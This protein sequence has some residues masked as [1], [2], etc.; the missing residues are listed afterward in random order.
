MIYVEKNIKTSFIL[1]YKYYILMVL[2][3]ITD[4]MDKGHIPI[5]NLTLTIPGYSYNNAIN[6]FK[7]LDKTSNNKIKNSYNKILL[8]NIPLLNI[9]ISECN[10]CG[11]K[12]NTLLQSKL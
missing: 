4:C 10:V 11:K 7:N 5:V 12:Y 6:N 1:I 3:S 9:I 8:K 2:N